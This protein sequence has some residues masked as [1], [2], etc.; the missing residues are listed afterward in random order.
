MNKVFPLILILLI[1]LFFRTYAVVGRYDFA[2]DHDLFSWIVKDIVVDNH[3]RL[4]GQLTSA[5]GIFIGAFFYYSL[6]PFF[7]LLSS[8]EVI[9]GTDWV[10]T[11]L[12]TEIRV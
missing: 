8:F 12:A 11:E 7:L 4:I 10:G 5:P 3:P 9:N 2:H 1:G 6:V